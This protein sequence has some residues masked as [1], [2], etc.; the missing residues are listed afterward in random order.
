MTE[1]RDDLDIL[2]LDRRTLRLRAAAGKD[3]GFTPLPLLE[4]LR[5]RGW[6]HPQ[7]VARLALA[8]AVGL[9]AVKRSWP[10]PDQAGAF[11]STH[12]PSESG[13]VYIGAAPRA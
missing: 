2:D 6:Y 9:H 3:P 12:P 5:R 10:H 4:I 8:A 11:V 13:C 7:D 1:A